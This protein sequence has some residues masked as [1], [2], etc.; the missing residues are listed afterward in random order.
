VLGILGPD[1]DYDIKLTTEFFDKQIDDY[2]SSP[3]DLY[4]LRS[5]LESLKT[6]HL[7]AEVALRTIPS[8]KKDYIDG[9]YKEL[10]GKIDGYRSA[11]TTWPLVIID[12]P[13]SATGLCNAIIRWVEQHR[14]LVKQ[15]PH[16]EKYLLLKLFVIVLN[17]SQIAPI[18]EFTRRR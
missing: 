3:N 7:P 8:G 18:S 11:K 10:I 15:K 1:L 14:E 13:Y 2:Q 5:I 9:I 6:F 16:L 12:T 17:V 4:I